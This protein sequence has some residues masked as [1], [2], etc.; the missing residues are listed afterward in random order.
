VILLCDEATELLEHE[1]ENVKASQTSTCFDIVLSHLL[2]YE[3]KLDFLVLN[4][5][6]NR[7]CASFS[8]VGLDFGICEN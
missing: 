6:N 8:K 1:V 7:C 5:S 3:V 4:A 2:L